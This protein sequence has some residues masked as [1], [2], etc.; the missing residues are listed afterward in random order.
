M[1]ALICGRWLRESQVLSDWK[2]ARGWILK[3]KLSRPTPKPIEATR[4]LFANDIHQGDKLARR[5]LDI[6]EREQ[7]ENHSSAICCFL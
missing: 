6:T 7:A 4:N 5:L 1:S 2:R 3:G